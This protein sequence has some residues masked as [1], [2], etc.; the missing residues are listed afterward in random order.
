MIVRTLHTA[1]A[2]TEAR[3]EATSEVI[4][5][6]MAE[7]TVETTEMIEAIETDVRTIECDLNARNDGKWID[8]SSPLLHKNCL[9]LLRNGTETQHH[10]KC[11]NRRR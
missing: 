6:V 1:A 4:A 5:E 7:A 3:P 11:I 2:T 10:R 8:L 9:Y